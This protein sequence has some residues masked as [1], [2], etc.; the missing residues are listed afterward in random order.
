[1]SIFKKAVPIWIKN[2]RTTPNLQAGFQCEF[3]ASGSKQY[4]LV[5]TGATLY[6]VFLNGKFAA[7]GPARAGHGYLR[8]DRLN[9]NVKNGKNYLAIEVAG[10]NCSSYYTI[11]TKS[12]LCAEILENNCVIAYTGRNFNALSLDSLR[13][14]Y[15][16]RYSYQ[17]AYGEVWNFDNSK[18]LTNWQSAD[19]LCSEPVMVCMVEEEFIEREVPYPDYCLDTSASLFE[20]GTVSFKTFEDADK[21]GYIKEMSNLRNGY[22]EEILTDDPIKELYGEFTPLPLRREEKKYTVS[23]GEY[24]MFSLDTN[25]T[26]FLIN[27]VIAEEDASVYIFFSEHNYSNGF[28]FDTL[29]GQTNIIKYNLKKSEIPYVLESFEPYTCK[30]IGIVSKGA[31]VR[32]TAPKMRE[33]SFP[34]FKNTAFVSKNDALNKIFAAAINTFR[35]NTLDVYT[36][37]P[38]RERGGWLCDSYFTSQAERLFAGTS[39]VEKVFL[40]NF[41]MAKE[42]PNLPA[43]MIPMTYPSDVLEY[44]GGFIPQWAMWYV[45]ELY[46]YCTLRERVDVSRYK[47]LCYDLLKWFEKYENTDGLLESMP[48]WNFV[49]WSQANEWVKDVNYPTNML[50]SKMLWSMAELFGDKS[51]EEK[52]QR[53]KKKIIEQS[54]NGRFF[55]DNAVR[56]EDGSLVPTGNISETCQYYAFFFDIVSHGDRQ[57]DYLTD[58]LLNKFEPQRTEKNILPEVSPSAPFIGN[59]LRLIILLRMKEFSKTISDIEGYF[60]SMAETTGTLWEHGI[61]RKAQRGGS[62]NHGFASMAAV[63]LVMACAGIS[64]I[65]YKEKKITIDAGYFCGFSYDIRINTPEGEIRIS[66]KKSEKFISLPD[67]WK[68]VK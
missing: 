36:D 42:F 66:E 4:T 53:V 23:D 5:L 1:M 21:P 43:G 51:L 62:L 8:C 20:N 10:Y 54:F 14:M 44:N 63:A 29:H 3:N 13:N 58:V 37:C 16:H 34:S 7:Y 31:D 64:L 39:I 18:N 40:E 22:E 52:S 60:L 65:N 9:L 61:L 35:Q 27:T 55:V 67:G 33:Y 26:G 41:V 19:N 30:Y 25:N 68:S 24:V 48:G 2:K 47:S 45:I 12:F 17:R 56:Q 28:C 38:G 46:D 59:Y 15:C 6:R 50:Y 49:E 32:I 11:A 57:F